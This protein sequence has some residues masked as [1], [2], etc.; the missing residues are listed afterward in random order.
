MIHGLTFLAL[1]IADIYRRRTTVLF[2]I[3]L[4]LVFVSPVE[5]W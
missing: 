4:T 1:K 2:C 5:I 3:G